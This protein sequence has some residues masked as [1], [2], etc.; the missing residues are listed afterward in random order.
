[1]DVWNRITVSELATSAKRDINDIFEAIFMSDPVRRY[2]KDTVIEDQ[3]VL[4]SAVRKLGAKFR[5]IPKP[6][7]KV[8]KD[9]K[10]YDAV[11][12]YYI[13]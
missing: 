12:R 6:D 5:V 11:K 2:N 4:Y 10:D 1:M 13:I 8:E 3:N 7:N 9:I